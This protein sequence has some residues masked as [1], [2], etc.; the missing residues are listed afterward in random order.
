MQKILKNLEENVAGFSFSRENSIHFQFTIIPWV[1]V[2][3]YVYN[4]YTV[5]YYCIYCMIL[6]QAAASDEI[7]GIF[8]QDIIL[9]Q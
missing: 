7:Y 3:I 9:R 8:Y 1:N 6:S 4:M 2:Q 5:Y